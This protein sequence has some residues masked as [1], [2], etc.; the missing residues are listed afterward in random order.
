MRIADWL[1]NP[2]DKWIWKQWHPI[3][4]SRISACKPNKELK[5]NPNESILHKLTW[6]FQSMQH[7]QLYFGLY[8]SE[9]SLIWPIYVLKSSATLSEFSFAGK[10]SL[11]SNWFI[12]SIWL[13]AASPLMYAIFFLL[14]VLFPLVLCCLSNPSQLSNL[15]LMPNSL[16]KDFSPAMGMGSSWRLQRYSTTNVHVISSWQFPFPCMKVRV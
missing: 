6:C 10:R 15:Q 9:Q 3:F 5:P 2:I 1:I 12:S 16:S 7:G 11:C 14:A 8:S 4:F 13:A